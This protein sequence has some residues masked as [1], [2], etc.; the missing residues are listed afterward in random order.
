MKPDNFDF[1]IMT[2]IKSM[3]QRKLLKQVN[4]AKALNTTESNYCKMENGKKAISIGQLK[5]IA[6]YLHTSI[7]QISKKAEKISH[8]IKVK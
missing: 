1:E 3:R 2:V 7:Q 5:I 6:E 4:L 8:I